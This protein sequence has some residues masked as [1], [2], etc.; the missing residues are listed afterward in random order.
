MTKAKTK[1]PAPSGMCVIW[2]Q[3][4]K[5]T[6]RCRIVLFRRQREAM[7]LS[8]SDLQAAIKIVVRFHRWDSGEL[9]R[10]GG[11]LR[12]DK[13]TFIFNADALKEH[14]YLCPLV[15]WPVFFQR[16]ASFKMYIQIT[17]SISSPCI[18]LLQ[19][20]MTSKFSLAHLQTIHLLMQNTQTLLT[21]PGISVTLLQN[22]ELGCV[23][24][25][26]GR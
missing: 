12:A 8:L 16:L 1:Q 19:I 23:E 13:S 17:W 4:K 3:F 2:R 7:K 11:G 5:L 22:T 26:G 18:L 24:E 15:V 20:S 6:T 21:L 25:G 10:P 14:R 9:I